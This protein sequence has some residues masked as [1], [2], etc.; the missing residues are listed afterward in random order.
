MINFIKFAY[1]LCQ[2]YTILQMS[3]RKEQYIKSLTYYQANSKG[4]INNLFKIGIGYSQM[5]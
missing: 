5:L 1:Q 4:L 3:R 2:E